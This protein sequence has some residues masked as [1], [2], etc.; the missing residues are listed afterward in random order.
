[1]LTTYY[2]LLDTQ[3]STGTNF[4]MRWNVFGEE[5][6]SHGHLYIGFLSCGDPDCVFMFAD[7]KDFDDLWHLL[8]SDMTFTRTMVYKENIQQLL[9]GHN[10][11]PL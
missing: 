2:L 5:C 11:P 1:M 4:E 8:P 3:P 9:F 6:F 10:A 7:Q